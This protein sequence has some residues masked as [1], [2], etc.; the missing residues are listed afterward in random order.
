MQCDLATYNNKWFKPSSKLK[1]ALWYFINTCFFKSSWNISTNVK[2]FWL[3]VFGA[4]IGKAVVIKPGV[5]I[6]YP[7]KLKIGN[8]CWIGEGVWLDNLDQ[9]TM[10]DSVCISQGAYLVCGNH[11]YKSSS[12]DLMIA[13]I[14]VKHGSWIGAK[15]IIG[16]GVTV[17]SHAVLSLGAVAT[18]D[19]EPYTVY[20]G[21]PAVAIHKRKIVKT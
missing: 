12:F 14:Y 21:N 9:I 10:E 8:H 5:N 1:R 17:G 13:P 20:S 3:R 4:D 7:W 6:K 19:L 16:P 15:G 11:N 18:K 2:T